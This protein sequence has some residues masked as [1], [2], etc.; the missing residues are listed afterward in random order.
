V[1]KG[2][3]KNIEPLGGV[4]LKTYDKT[5]GYSLIAIKKMSITAI[6]E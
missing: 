3:I 4:G 2:Q 6:P 1:L 5:L